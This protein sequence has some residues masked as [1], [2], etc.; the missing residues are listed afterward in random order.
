MNT[1]TF[2]IKQ[3]F[4]KTASLNIIGNKILIQHQ[5]VLRTKLLCQDQQVLLQLHI[6]M[7]P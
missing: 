3:K 7:S 2:E 5:L 6:S 1:A 4:S